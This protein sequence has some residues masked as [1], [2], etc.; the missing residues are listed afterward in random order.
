MK[1]VMVKQI[2]KLDDI[3]IN[4]YG[5]PSLALMENAGKSVAQ[6]AIRMVAKKKRP[7][8]CVVCGLGNNAG[9]GF[10]V[11][12][13]LINAG[14]EPKIFLIG[15]VAKLKNDALVNCRILKKCRYPIKEAQKVTPAFKKELQKADLIVDAIFGVGLNREVGVPFK[16]FIE[17]VNDSKKP[18]LAVDAP[19]GLDGTTGKIYGVCVKAKK[20]VTFSF[21][22]KGFYK[23]HGPEVIG[24]V[25]VV[26]IGIPKRLK[27][28]KFM[29]KN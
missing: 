28:M 27:E 12:R 15:K 10:V 1:T 16:S 17:A 7:C 25:V 9:D 29:E 20:T 24:K 8:V 11:A 4:Q 26:D 2:Q 23:A 6:E 21:A 5:V 19:S 14:I 3:A 13:H 18:V 22:K